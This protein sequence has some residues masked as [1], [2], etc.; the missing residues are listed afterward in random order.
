MTE[1]CLRTGKPSV[2]VD[3]KAFKVMKD[4]CYA[5]HMRFFNYCFCPFLPR[6]LLKIVCVDNIKTTY[7][8]SCLIA[9]Q[10]SYARIKT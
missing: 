4:N 10:S 3:H 8:V 5:L 6:I 2:D 7:I 9:M 1:L